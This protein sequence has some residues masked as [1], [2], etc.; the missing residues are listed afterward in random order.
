MEVRSGYGD[1]LGDDADG[2]GRGDRPL[3][4]LGMF[5]GRD[6]KAAE[7]SAAADEA[8]ASSLASDGPGLTA[9]PVKT[10]SIQTHSI[11]KPLRA[12]MGT[13]Y[14][15]TLAQNEES[16]F[17]FTAPGVTRVV[18]DARLVPQD[19]GYISD[20]VYLLDQDG[21]RIGNPIVSLNAADRELRAIELIP[22]KRG[23]VRG[24]KVV[25]ESGYLTD[26]WLTLQPSDQTSFVPLFGEVVPRSF[27]LSQAV[28]GVL[29]KHESL[30]LIARFAKGNYKIIVDAA[31][32]GGR[33]GYLEMRMSTMDSRGGNH[34][35]L[36]Y[37]SHAGTSDRE[38]ATLNVSR[39]QSII[40]RLQ[41]ASSP[42]DYTF[43]ITPS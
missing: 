12:A 2:R 3:N 40:F 21:E 35:S 16:F 28:S 38:S 33:S 11:D 20:K 4:Q 17:T 34:H 27:K 39:D 41:G 23:D 37:I 32:P 26:L 36:V 29:E 1:R 7:Q 19:A 30:Y 14:R 31:H 9:A 43:R 25:N 15:L 10:R 8:D 6:H 22:L 24:L 5:K 18:L 13:T 42:V